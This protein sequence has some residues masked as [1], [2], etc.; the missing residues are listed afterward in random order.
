MTCGSSVSLAPRVR[1]SAT[2]TPATGKC[3]HFIGFSRGLPVVQTQLRMSEWRPK[4]NHHQW[5]K[6]YPKTSLVKTETI[7]FHLKKPNNYEI[8]TKKYTIVNP[9]PKSYVF[10][11]LGAKD[12]FLMRLTISPWVKRGGSTW[13]V[14]PNSADWQR[15]FASPIIPA[16]TKTDQKWL[17]T[18][19]VPHNSSRSS[20]TNA[21]ILAAM[22][23]KPRI[24]RPLK[25][26]FRH[27][28]R[29]TKHPQNKRRL[30]MT[31]SAN[32]GCLLGK[33]SSK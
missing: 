15:E 14:R 5:P 6:L 18:H 2:C 12:G 8:S 22:I 31:F 28:T 21:K 23:E 17:F 29:L 27:H 1:A 11:P 16:T 20:A 25:L 26:V 19:V 3:K 10:T 30:Y 24:I 32:S 4:T 13:L 33:T 7:Y 9:N